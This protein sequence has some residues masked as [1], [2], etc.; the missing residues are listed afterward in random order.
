ML[1]TVRYFIFFLTLLAIKGCSQVPES[2]FYE[3]EGV[4]SIRAEHGDFDHH[5][6]IAKHHTSSPL[7]LATYGRSS[8]SYRFY[9][10][11]PG[12]YSLW[13]LSGTSGEA[14]LDNN[15]LVTVSD[16]DNFLQFQGTMPPKNTEHL[17]WSRLQEESV[18]VEFDKPGF[19]DVTFHFEDHFGFLLG[20]IHLS[21]NNTLPPSGY[22]FPETTQPDIDPILM[23]RQQP[24][25]IPPAWA[26]GLMVWAEENQKEVFNSLFVEGISVDAVLNRPDRDELKTPLPSIWMDDEHIAYAHV[27]EGSG[28]EFIE[29]ELNTLEGRPFMLSGM[30][31]LSDPDFKRLPAK[32]LYFTN[33]V[34]SERTISEA[35]KQRIEMVANPLLATSEAPF[36]SIGMNPLI[37][38]AFKEEITDDILM[39]WVQFS[40]LTGLMHLHI[41]SNVNSE[42]ISAEVM[43]EIKKMTRLRSRLFPYLYSLAH[44]VRATANNPVRGDGEHTTQF[45]L[46]EA[47]LVAPVYREGN[48]SRTTWFPEGTWYDY[49]SG[50]RIEGGQTWLV[51]APIRQIPLFVKAGSIIPYRSEAGQIMT[52]SNHNL[53]IEIYAGGVGTFRLYE[54]DGTTNRYRSGK[55]A[56]TGFRYFETAEYATFTIGKTVGEY[57]GLPKERSIVLEF[58][59]M[60]KPSQVSANSKMLQTGSENEEWVY[61]VDNQTLIIQWNQPTDLKTDFKIRF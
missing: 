47:F 14:I 5:W 38:D 1:Y 4:I 18:Y 17:I 50:E 9:I 22:G 60:P 55:L 7:Q 45:Q 42:L 35:L 46:G 59:N 21:K 32:W 31:N 56:T 20:K 19:F 53:T 16:Q 48:D 52:G 8:A 36:L 26:F 30:Q 33:S 54:D 12:S 23:K 10:Q 29:D 58:L 57:E 28:K 11:S 49:W 39:R 13:I 27:V 61:D 43:D 2:E 41:P 37:T 51:D 15:I 6:V 3:S 40:S 24:V 34:L 25:L 44:L